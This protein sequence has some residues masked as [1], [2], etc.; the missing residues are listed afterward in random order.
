MRMFEFRSFCIAPALLGLAL[1]APVVATPVVATPAA[2]ATL[3][4]MTMLHAPVVRLADLFDDAG[5]NA[6]RVLGPGPGAGGRIVVEAPQLAAIARQFGVDWRPASPADRAVLE[7][8]GRLLAQSDVTAAL[9]TA[10]TAAGA[11][12]DCEIELPGFTPPTVPVEA[13]PKPLATALQFDAAS[14]HFTALLSI[15]GD[16]M[17]PLNLRVAGQVDETIELPVAVGR[18][19]AGTVLRADDVR[20][21]RVHVAMVHGEVLHR[22]NEAVGMELRHPVMAGMPFLAADVARPTLVQRGANVTMQLESPGLSVVAQGVAMDPG[23]I[24]EQIRVMNPSSR[25][26]V[27]AV[28]IGPGQVRVT[29][30]SIP[31]TTASRGNQTWVP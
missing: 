26:T 5:A 16:G 4:T 20:M 18:L 13:S 9:K 8:P 2:A 25:A 12:A 29:P 21:A 3:R 27:E 1:L 10:L 19:M 15:T 11:S 28:V 17:D 30:D 24:G 31:L 14:G 6:D 23:A 7:R 22:P